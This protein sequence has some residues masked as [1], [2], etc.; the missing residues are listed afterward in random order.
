[1]DAAVERPDWELSLTELMS[2]YA[3]YLAGLAWKW[4]RRFPQAEFDDLLAEAQVG[5]LI[6]FPKYQRERHLKFTAYATWW[7]VKRMQAYV[8]NTLSRGVKVPESG[9]YERFST[10]EMKRQHHP[11]YHPGDGEFADEWW[12]GVLA[13]L[14]NERDREMIRAMFEDDLVCREI[15]E[16]YGISRNRA[17]FILLRSLETIR[18]RQPHLESQIVC[19][20][21]AT[22]Q[23]TYSADA[24]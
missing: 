17:N 8:R 10:I 5:F 20:G 19:A 14:P 16:R 6:A 18:R 21:R 4:K 15:G 13:A 1:M 2:R 9:Q 11:T 7:A 22:G 23:R 24:K 12:T 3:A